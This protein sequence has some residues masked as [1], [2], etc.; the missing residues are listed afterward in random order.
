[1]NI[2]I[3]SWRNIW[4]RKLSTILSL[5]LM[6]LGIAIISMMILFQSQLE[7]RF[8][9]NLAGIDMVVGA[10][11]SPLQLI[12]SSVFHLDA[13]T[14]NIPLEEAEELSRNRLIERSIPV[15]Y[16]DTYKG[17][18]IVGTTTEF[19]S[20]YDGKV[21]TGKIWSE[22]MEVVVGYRVAE[23]FG[24]EIGNKL[25]SSHGLGKEGALHED[26]QFEVVGIL[27]SSNTILDQL[28]LTNT[29]SIWDVHA[30]EGEEE[31]G[32]KEITSLLIE[33]SSPMGLIRLPRMINQGTSMM[34][35]LPAYEINRLFGLLGIGFDTLNLIALVIVIVSAVSVF[36]SL[37]NSLKDRKHELA[38]LRSYGATRGQIVWLI[39]FEG[40][41]LTVMGTALG[42]VTSR[43]GLWLVSRQAMETYNQGFDLTVFHPNEGLLMLL[44]L[45]LGV[46]SAL[47]PAIQAYRSDISR[48]LE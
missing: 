32:P 34:A 11:G 31:E 33:F 35:A 1:M 41:I 9:R 5:I 20:L 40:L 22:S 4:Q 30:H 7:D 29:E 6:M 46:F 38:L 45:G 14:G 47:L 21:G 28:I 36:I 3:L 13:P 26:S 44:A 42:I 15:S 12:L 16:G 43:F 8:T 2:F 10:K 18:R 23:I 24:L 17:Y 37:Y 48:L 19:L 27:E 39:L 25:I